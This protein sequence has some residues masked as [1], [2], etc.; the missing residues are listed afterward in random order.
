[1]D[2]TPKLA[3]ADPDTGAYSHPQL[4]FITMHELQ[5]ASFSSGRAIVRAL[6][7]L[8]F[9]ALLFT[10]ARASAAPKRGEWVETNVLSST[11]M[12]RDF[13]AGTTTSWRKQVNLAGAIGLHY[14]FAD[15]L[16]FGTSVQYTER[17]WPAPPPD[18][19]RFQRFAIMP[20]LAWNFC[21]PFFVATLFNY[22]PRTRGKALTD[23]SVSVMLGAGVALS[24]RVRLGVS[25][26]APYAFYYH[27]ALS[28]VALTGVSVVL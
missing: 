23:M 22:A 3:R 20:Q 6:A 13:D 1:M 9:C 15:A 28:L 19:S 5:C 11:V 8:G 14:Y 4:A 12:S 2:V 21:D 7:A 10:A 25:V 17:I 16:R 18:S 27:R 24:K 26:E